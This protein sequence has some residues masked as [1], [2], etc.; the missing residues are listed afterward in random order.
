[1]LHK[2]ILASGIKIMIT[3]RIQE[4]VSRNSY[5]ADSGGGSAAGVFCASALC[6]R[7]LVQRKRTE[8][9]DEI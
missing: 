3:S 6:V 9:I 1:M 8:E 4:L 2:L 7:E 5:L